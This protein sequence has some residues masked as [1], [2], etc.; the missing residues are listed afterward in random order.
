[1]IAE[2]DVRFSM[3]DDSDLRKRLRAC[4][5]AGVD[6]RLRGVLFRLIDSAPHSTIHSMRGQIRD[7]AQ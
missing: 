7:L 2:Q 1:M 5:N 4:V 3:R 6:D